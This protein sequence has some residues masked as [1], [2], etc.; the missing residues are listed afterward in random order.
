MTMFKAMT[1]VAGAALLAAAGLMLVPGFSNEVVAR[2]PTSMTKGDRLDVR[3]AH[4]NCAAQTWP[5]I[6]AACLRQAGSR[7]V[8]REARIVSPD[9]K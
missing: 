1:A 4:L 8:V 3:A 9:R 7:T 2:T 5:A 6:D